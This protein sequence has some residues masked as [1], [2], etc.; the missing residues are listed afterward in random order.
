MDYFDLLREAYEDR[1]LENAGYTVENRHAQI[2]QKSLANKQTN[3]RTNQI[4]LHFNLQSPRCTTQY[5]PLLPFSLIVSP[6]FF[7]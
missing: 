2:A 5:R 6:I 3:K 1:D 4:N 7:F